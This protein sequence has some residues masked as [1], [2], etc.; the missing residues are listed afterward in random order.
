MVILTGGLR[1][2]SVEATTELELGVVTAESLTEVLGLNTA[3]GAF[4]KAIADRFVDVEAQLRALQAER[5]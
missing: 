3:I 2:S 1:T 4:A 5:R